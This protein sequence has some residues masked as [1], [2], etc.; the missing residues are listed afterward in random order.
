MPSTEK[1]PSTAFEKLLGGDQATLARAITLLE[2]GGDQADRLTARLRPHTGRAHVIAVT[3]PP[4][5]GKSTLINSFISQIRA[6]DQAVA[7]LAVDP[8]SPLSG[9]AVLGDR[10]RMGAHT[11]DRS[12]FIRSIASRGHLGG[13]ALSVPSILDAVDAAGWPYIILETVGAGQS[14]TE[15]A[16]FADIKIVVNAPGLGDGVQAIKAGILEIADIL[17]VNKS[18]LPLADRTVQQLKG[19]L[20]LRA[21]EAR[22][23]PI[24]ATT[25][26]SGDGIQELL[27]KTLELLSTQ[28]NTPTDVRIANRLRGSVTRRAEKLAVRYISSAPDP[29]IS[30]LCASVR[31]GEMS[32]DQAAYKLLMTQLFNNHQTQVFDSYD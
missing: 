22:D 26:T 28:K 19:M 15:V 5:A 16:E 29:F 23:V 4:G 21:A 2:A 9:G 7:V 12:V 32:T 11:R 14:E 31:S 10:T 18:D 3:G 25:A 13:L 1:N 20:E 17:V 24:I 27:L 6:Q 8:S 30:G